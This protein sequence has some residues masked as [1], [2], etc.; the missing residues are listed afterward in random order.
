M[1]GKQRCRILKQIRK[2]IADANGL[3]VLARIPIDPELAKVCDAGAVELFE[4]DYLAGAVTRLLD[5][6]K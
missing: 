6:K 3:D 1:K 5:G 4:G 2:E